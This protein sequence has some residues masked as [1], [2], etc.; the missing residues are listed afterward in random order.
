MNTYELQSANRYNQLKG[1]TQ[2]EE[3]QTYCSRLGSQVIKNLLLEALQDENYELCIILR[4]DLKR[5]K[6]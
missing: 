3:Q 1:I 5:R 2:K 6:A 4:D